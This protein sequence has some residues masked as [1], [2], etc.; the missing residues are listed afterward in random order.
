MNTRSRGFMH[1]FGTMESTS[2]MAFGHTST[3]RT[4]QQEQTQYPIAGRG[5]MPT[6]DTTY[7]TYIIISQH[8]RKK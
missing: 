6:Q 1:A 5:D 4:K 7:T 3:K 2:S 8:H